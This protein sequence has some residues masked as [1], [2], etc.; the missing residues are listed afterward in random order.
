MRGCDEKLY[1]SERESGNVWEE[2]VERI[3]NDENNWDCNVEGDAVEGPVF[4]V[5]REEVLQA[6]DEMK[7][8][9]AP[10]PSEVSQELVP[11]SGGV[12]VQVIAEI[13]QS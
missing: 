7:T 4:C 5:S 1:L 2:Y 8:G 11:T 12:V 3:M 10:E 9:K 6:L 13:C